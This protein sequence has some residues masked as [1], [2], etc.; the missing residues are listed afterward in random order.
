MVVITGRCWCDGVPVL[1]LLV[2]MVVVI[3][4][5]GLGHCQF[6]TSSQNN[7]CEDVQVE[8]KRFVQTEHYKVFK[9]RN[10]ESVDW[11]I[12]F[13]NEDRSCE[14]EDNSTNNSETIPI[15]ATISKSITQNQ[16]I[17]S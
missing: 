5:G 9:S 3:A 16:G 13:Q 11:L 7:Q 8:S 10:C 17:C 2:T 15:I 4:D 12:S 1:L 6:Q 14:T